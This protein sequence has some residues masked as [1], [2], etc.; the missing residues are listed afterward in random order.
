M[1]SEIFEV[2]QVLSRYVRATDR[3]DGESLAALFVDEGVVEILHREDGAEAVLGTL[4]GRKAIAMAVTTMMKP[5][6]LHEW[7]HHTTFDP[8]TSIDGDRAALDA[9]FIVFQIE[10]KPRPANGWGNSVGAQGGIRPTESGY[11]RAD[12]RRVDREWRIERLRIHHDL[13]FAIPGSGE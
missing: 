10:G 7:S 9:Q 1:V 3:R 13:P 12:L 5:H 11:Y 4:E 2:Q 6:G 8:I